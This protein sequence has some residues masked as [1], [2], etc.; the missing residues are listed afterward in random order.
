MLEVLALL[1]SILVTPADATELELDKNWHSA[2][3]PIERKSKTTTKYDTKRVHKTYEA[4]KAQHE[5][6]EKELN[7][8]K[9]RLDKKFESLDK[10][11]DSHPEMKDPNWVNQEEPAVVKHSN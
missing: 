3:V 11:P 4:P 10:E 6:S 5:V 8:I 1:P 9:L 2:I 7:D